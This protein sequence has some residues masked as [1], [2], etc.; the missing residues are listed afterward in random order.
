M[1]EGECSTPR[2]AR[3]H[4]QPC[5]HRK[6]PGRSPGW[7]GQPTQPRTLPTVPPARRSSMQS[8]PAGAEATSVSIS[9]QAQCSLDPA[10]RRVVKVISGYPGQAQ[11][12]VQG[13]RQSIGRHWPPG[14]GRQRGS[15]SVVC[16]VADLLGLLVS[17]RFLLEKPKPFPRR[18]IPL[19]SST[20]CPQGRHSV[21]PSG[22]GLL[23]APFAALIS[24]LTAKSRG[25]S[26]YLRKWPD[27]TG[28]AEPQALAHMRL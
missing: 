26:N 2:G 15:G 10:L 21:E 11:A 4:G 13:G 19:A 14:D 17:G 9:C 20:G 25:L 6:L 7:M 8:P 28:S 27:A 12:A 1:N 23:T 16:S 22:L 5:S 3:L 24:A 18:S